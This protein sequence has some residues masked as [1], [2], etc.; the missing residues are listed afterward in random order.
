[1][2]IGFS[3]RTLQQLYISLLLVSTTAS[4]ITGCFPVASATSEQ[5]DSISFPASVCLCPM[6]VAISGIEIRAVHSVV[7]SVSARTRRTAA[8]DVDCVVRSETAHQSHSTSLMSP[9]WKLFPVLPCVSTIVSHSP[10]DRGWLVRV[11]ASQPGRTDE[12]EPCRGRGQK[13]SEI[14]LHTCTTLN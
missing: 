11:L 10:G 9:M 4:S 5:M 6:S 8:L 3:W 2:F 13:T 14:K 7:V 1:M 12:G